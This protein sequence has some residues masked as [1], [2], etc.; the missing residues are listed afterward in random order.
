MNSVRYLF[1]AVIT[2]TLL[3][4]GSYLAA[5]PYAISPFFSSLLMMALPLGLGVFLYRRL[6]ADWRVFGL[7]MLTFLGSQVLHLPFNNWTYL[8]ILENLGFGLSIPPG[9]LQLALFAFLIGLSS[10]VFE[11]TARYIVY[12]R[13]LDKAR[14][15]KDGLMFGAGHGGVEALFIGV[16]ALLYFLNA[17]T[18]RNGDLSQLTP[19]QFENAQLF[20]AA[21]WNNPWHIYLLPLIERISAMIFHL[22]AALLVLQAFTRRNILWYLA[23]VLMHAS[24]NALGVFAQVTWGDYI[25]EGLLLLAALFSLWI[26]FALRTEEDETPSDDLPD[27]PPKSIKEIQATPDSATTEKL[28]ESRYD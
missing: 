26:I 3:C 23:A 21:Y 14:S 18:V 6:K 1:V 7:G 5:A 4:I 25:A 15:W 20:S 24:F 27:D 13:W 11:E 19:E 12:S 9:S 2:I 10:G 17:L 22:S 8:P 28:E 16:F